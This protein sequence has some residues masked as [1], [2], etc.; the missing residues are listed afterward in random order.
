MVNSGGYRASCTK[1]PAPGY[2]ARAPEEISISGCAVEVADVARVPAV[3]IAAADQLAEVVGCIAVVVAV[4]HRPYSCAGEAT[5]EHIF[6]PG[7]QD[8][9]VPVARNG[10]GR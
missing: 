1:L 6:M 3:R 2:V 7:R 4:I 10:L 8:K 9:S 5:A